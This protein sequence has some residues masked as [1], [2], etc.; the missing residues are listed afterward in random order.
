MSAAPSEHRSRFHKTV[1]HQNAFHL[2]MR[3]A[4][5][6]GSQ[7]EAD[8]RRPDYSISTCKLFINISF[9]CEFQEKETSYVINHRRTVI[10][11]QIASKN[12]VI[13]LLFLA[14]CKPRS[15][16]RNASIPVNLYRMFVMAFSKLK[17]HNARYIYISLKCGPLRKYLMI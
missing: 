15:S 11:L 14:K 2:K 7:H 9:S 5:D 13:H 1:P 10:F 6:A 17:Y 4:V 8:Y 16:L 3:P 12:E